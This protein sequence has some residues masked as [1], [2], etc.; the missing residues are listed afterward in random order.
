MTRLTAFQRVKMAIERQLADEAIAE[1]KPESETVTAVYTGYNNGYQ[2]RTN[3]GGVVRAEVLST[4]EPEIGESY[5]LQK[6]AGS[7]VFIVKPKPRL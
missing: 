5:L 7:D 3:N 1:A 6:Q 4:S 2:F